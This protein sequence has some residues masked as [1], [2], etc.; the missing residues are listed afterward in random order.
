MMQ[1]EEVARVPGESCF[2]LMVKPI[3]IVMT[4]T[5]TVGRHDTEKE[6]ASVLLSARAK[7]ALPESSKCVLV[8]QTAEKSYLSAPHHA[9]LVE[10]RWGGSTHITVEERMWKVEILLWPVGALGLG[11]SFYHHEVVKNALFLG[12]ETRTA[13]PLIT[14]LLKEAAEEGIISSSQMSKGFSR[15]ALSLDDL[16]RDIPS[17]KSFFQS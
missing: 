10:R 14:K 13:E 17:A 16:V 6:M 7:K 9:E 8:I 2:I 1:R 3:L 11:V 15:L 12:M 4:L 5:M